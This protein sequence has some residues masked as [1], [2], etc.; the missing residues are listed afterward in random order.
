[1]CSEC[2]FV[3]S[4]GL[5]PG[6]CFWV[7]GICQHRCAPQQQSVQSTLQ[8]ANMTVFLVTC[9]FLLGAVRSRRGRSL[10][11]RRKRTET[12]PVL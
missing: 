11:I 8:S 4:Q 5:S 12:C 1:M 2:V 3:A 9:S 10:L 7:K 6:S